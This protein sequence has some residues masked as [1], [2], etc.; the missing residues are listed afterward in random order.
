MNSVEVHFAGPEVAAKTHLEDQ[1]DLATS[2]LRT[3]AD[4][5]AIIVA[6]KAPYNVDLAVDAEPMYLDNPQFHRAVADIVDSLPKK[7]P[8]LLEDEQYCYT[9]LFALAPYF[10]FVQGDLSLR[11]DQM[12][13]HE[14][15]SAKEYAS[16]FN[17]A[18]RTVISFNQHIPQSAL[19]EQLAGYVN[20][21][22]APDFRGSN[23]SINTIVTT[24][25]NGA[26]QEI[27]FEQ[28]CDF[29]E[30]PYKRG[31][32]DD[33]LSGRDYTIYGQKV[34]IKRSLTRFKDKS[35]QVEAQYSHG[36]KKVLVC[37]LIP[38]DVFEGMKGNETFV[39]KKAYLHTREPQYRNMFN[40]ISNAA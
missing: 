29:L 17:D 12:S 8:E 28:I 32:M 7:I 39:H 18:L 40:A 23:L 21:E 16:M 19:A 15:L 5:R 14:I 4:S 6:E 37:P 11:K 1:V 26:A 38:L 31:D 25:I 2:R 34:D 13:S 35:H 30:V 10:A 33:D 3:L 27:A 9:R 22:V 24:A 20:S 36:E